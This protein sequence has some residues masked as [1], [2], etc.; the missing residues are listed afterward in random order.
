MKACAL[1]LTIFASL[2]GC[3]AKTSIIGHVVD[4]QGKPIQAASVWLI[5][6]DWKPLDTRTDYQGVFSTGVVHSSHSDQLALL[7]SAPGYKLHY[8]LIAS[9]PKHELQVTLHPGSQTE[10]E[11]QSN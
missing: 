8:Q 7:V 1:F 10:L 5:Y 2:A 11:V 4:P 9:Q 6:S 3:D